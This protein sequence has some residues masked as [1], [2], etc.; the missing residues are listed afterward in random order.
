METLTF[1]EKKELVKRFVET[2]NDNKTLTLESETFKLILYEQHFKE[3][4]EYVVKNGI[5]EFTIYMESVHIDDFE[6]QQNLLP[7]LS[8]DSTYTITFSTEYGNGWLDTQFVGMCDCKLIL[9]GI[10]LVKFY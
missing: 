4:F 9:F 7:I 5:H 3:A 2:Y 1:K 10:T 8:L 6:C